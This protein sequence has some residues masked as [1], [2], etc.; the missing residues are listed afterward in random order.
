[1]KLTKNQQYLLGGAVVLGIILYVRGR[2]EEEEALSS[3]CGGTH[4]SY[5]SYTGV[6]GSAGCDALPPDECK[7]QCEPKYGTFN[8]DGQG[9]N[10]SCDNMHSIGFDTNGGVRPIRHSKFVIQEW[11]D[12]R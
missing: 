4:N 11:L 5:S 3:A 1:M 6:G 10:G 8:P 12:H 7:K 2:K 9:G